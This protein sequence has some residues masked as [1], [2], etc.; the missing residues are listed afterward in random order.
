MSL[1]WR[2]S[3]SGVMV[4][5]CSNPHMW[6]VEYPHLSMWYDESTDVGCVE[7]LPLSM[8]CLWIDLW[9]LATRHHR[10]RET[11]IAKTDSSPGTG[12]DI[13]LFFYFCVLKPVSV[14]D[15]ILVVGFPSHYCCLF[16]GTLPWHASTR[17]PSGR[18]QKAHAVLALAIGSG[19]QKCLGAMWR[20]D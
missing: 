14:L 9:C 6:F 7:S 13:F 18:A 1:R 8:W 11:R 15:A 17:T 4:A 3:R 19:T 2:L 5:V 20:C 10:H 16:T 12:Q